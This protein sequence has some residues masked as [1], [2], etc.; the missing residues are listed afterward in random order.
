M[1]KNNLEKLKELFLKKI[2]CE[3][4]IQQL[5]LFVDKCQTNDEEL[6]KIICKYIILID[7]L[8][9]EK[10]NDNMKNKM[11]IVDSLKSTYCVLQYH[12]KNKSK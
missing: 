9:K 5:K 7:E 2:T 4:M 11:R 1:T 6:K 12:I 8:S 10:S 3:Q